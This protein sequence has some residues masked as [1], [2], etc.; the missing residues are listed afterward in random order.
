MMKGMKNMN[1][2]E[3]IAETARRHRHLTRR[4]VK[5]AVEIYLELLA[6]EI[7]QGEWVELWII[8]KI[9]IIEEQGSGNLRPKV[10]GSVSIEQKTKKRLRT[11]IRLAA[12]FKKR[13]YKSE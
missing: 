4:L 1:H 12:S 8:G 2:T 7:A 10:V 3:R 5:E 11:K 6:E 13:C 9:Q